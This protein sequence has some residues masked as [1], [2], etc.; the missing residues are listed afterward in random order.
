MK[1]YIIK[2][3]LTVFIGVGAAFQ[4]VKIFCKGNTTLSIDD[5]KNLPYV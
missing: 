4:D 2:D 3:N 1:I 5:W